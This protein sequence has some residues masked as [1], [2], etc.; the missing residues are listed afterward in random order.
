MRNS[1][2]KFIPIGLLL[3]LTT[4]S[5]EIGGDDAMRVLNREK[6][7]LKNIYDNI[8]ARISELDAQLA[9]LDTSAK[10]KL[11]LVTIGDIE[12]KPFQHFFE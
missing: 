1:T 9:E 4:C 5:P 12:P 11:M 3:L 2:L 6:D 8:G 10:S 7:S